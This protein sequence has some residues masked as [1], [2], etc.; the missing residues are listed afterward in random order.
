MLNLLGAHKIHIFFISDDNFQIHWRQRCFSKVLFQNACQEACSTE[1]CFW[2]CW[3]QHD[4]KVEGEVHYF[5][6]LTVSSVS[7]TCLFIISSVFSITQQACGFEYTS[8]LQRMF[9]D[10]SLSKDMNERFKMNVSGSTDP[11][12]SM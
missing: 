8:K 7:F 1:L 2:W 9:Q 12:N 10:I 4:L 11:L 5:T 3:S 6:S